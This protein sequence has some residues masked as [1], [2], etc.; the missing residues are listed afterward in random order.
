MLI[1]LMS[2]QYLNSLFLSQLA[3]DAL[4]PVKIPYFAELSDD[5]ND[6]HVVCMASLQVFSFL[7]YCLKKVCNS[8]AQ[9]MLHGYFG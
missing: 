8:F 2:R 1:K 9:D 7:S 4:L 3:H 5:C 6:C